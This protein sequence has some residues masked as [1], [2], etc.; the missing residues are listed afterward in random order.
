MGKLYDD[1]KDDIEERYDDVVENMKKTS[2]ASEIKVTSLE[3]K[4]F[5]VTD[6]NS[7]ID[8]G[9]ISA[10]ISYKS[11]YSGEFAKKIDDKEEKK[12]DDG[13]LTGTVSFRYDDGEWKIS[14]IYNSRIYYYWY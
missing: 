9:S 2:Y 4:Q 13:N 12:N 10:T 5:E 3:L 1:N 7:Y 11:E 14:R 8:N 6:Q